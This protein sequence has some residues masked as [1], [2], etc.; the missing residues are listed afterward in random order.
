MHF[1]TPRDTMGAM[2]IEMWWPKIRQESRDWL[3]ANN[4][5]L[6]RQDIVDE[7]VRAGGVVT[8]AY[9]PDEV[10]DWVEAVANGERPDPPIERG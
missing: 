10:V 6:V 7:I 5:D 3:V 9:L 4:G 1:T 8:G 2:S